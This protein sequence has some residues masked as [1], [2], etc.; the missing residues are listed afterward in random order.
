[1]IQCNF[2]NKIINGN[3]KRHQQ[4]KRCIKIQKENENKK[5]QLTCPACNISLCS[6]Y[7]LENH[8]KICIQY[9]LLLKDKQYEEALLLKDKQHEEQLN[10]KDKQ[11]EEELSAK[12]KQI[13]ILN[14][15]NWSWNNA[16]RND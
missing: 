16:K 7:S 9:Q 6:K 1:M 12:D 10:A 2:C 15:C 5:K 8:Q 14:N 3:L 4:T 13:H 11:H